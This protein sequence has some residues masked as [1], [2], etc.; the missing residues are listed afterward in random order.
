M[1]AAHCGGDEVMV[2]EH[3]VGRVYANPTRAGQASFD[4]EVHGAGG[5]FF[6]LRLIAFPDKTTNESSGYSILA[7]AFREK[8]RKVPAGTAGFFQ[9]LVRRLRHALR[10]CLILDVVE[11][12]VV[13]IQ[14]RLD[15]WAGTGG[16]ERGW[17]LASG[18]RSE[19]WSK[20]RE[21]V[22]DILG[23]NMQSMWLQ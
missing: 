4:P 19:K 21:L 13:E 7:K 9:C 1:S 11:N 23:R 20:N 18:H 10:P 16:R 15:R 6:G 3:A 17:K 22:L 14:N 8:S 12:P 2:C 5:A